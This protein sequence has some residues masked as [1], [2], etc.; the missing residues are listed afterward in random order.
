MFKVSHLTFKRQQQLICDDLTFSV[1]PGEVWGV[2]GENGSGKTT[3]LHTLCGLYPKQKGYIQLG[4]ED[5]STLSRFAIAKKIGLLFQELSQAFSQTV[6]E[7][8]LASR[9]P[10]LTYFKRESAHDLCIV[11][12]ALRILDLNH[13]HH[14]LIS[15]LSGGEKRRLALAALIAQTP[16][17]YLLD[18]PTNH[19]DLR[20]Q[21]KILQH[22]KY[23]ADTQKIKVIMTMHDVNLARQF[24][25][26]VLLIFDDGETLQGTPDKM[27]T[28]ANLSRL[29]HHPI[30]VIAHE[31]RLFWYPEI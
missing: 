5:L 28:S 17:L 1:N 6:A 2:L 20:Y 3:L 4:D 23:L 24:C 14:R 12:D 22:F 8:C 16:E 19:L 27:L 30:N 21:I 31:D 18:E 7:Y 9:Y 10:H 26:R 15:R 13:L 25:D 29:Y 11:N